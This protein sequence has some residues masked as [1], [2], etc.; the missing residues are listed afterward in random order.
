VKILF[1]EDAPRTLRRHFSGHEIVTV[2][3]MGW[4]GIKNGKLLA[5]A[6][7]QD[8]EVLLT[9]DQNLPYQQNLAGRTIA[10]LVIVVLNKRM[11]TLLPLVPEIFA[12]LPM[13]QPGYVFRVEQKAEP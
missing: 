3:E 6:E 10:I 1:D 13:V 12:M 2:Q 9:F 5:L 4:A 11:E 8:F 7:G